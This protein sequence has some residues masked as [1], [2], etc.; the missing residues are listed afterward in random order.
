MPIPVT[1]EPV[2]N[3]NEN[4][5]KGAEFYATNCQVCHGDLTG[6]GGGQEHLPITSMAIRGTTLMLI[7]KTGS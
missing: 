4:I 3:P 2:S 7:S 1:H 6:L 5:A